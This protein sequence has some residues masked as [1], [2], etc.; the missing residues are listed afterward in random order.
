M[1][2]LNEIKDPSII[3]VTDL[4]SC[5]HRYHMKKAYPE[6]SILFEPAAILGDIAHWGLEE[7]LRS[8]NLEV[9][10]EASR[11]FNVDGKVYLVKGRVDAV[12]RI[13]GLVVEIKTAR[14]AANLPRTHHV[15]QLNV[16]LEILGLEEGVLVYITPEKILEYVVV[17]EHIDLES[18]IR[19]LVRDSY[20]PIY[21]WECQY[22][23][24]KKMCPYS[25]Y[26]K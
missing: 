11:S 15:K 3:Y 22:C 13:R 8:K 6:L 23:V 10:V 21:E 4:V 5:T 25:V 19:E 26:T 1:R 18:E 7:L 2:R 20:H 14:S 9:E 17:K 16:Y 12:D 24:Y